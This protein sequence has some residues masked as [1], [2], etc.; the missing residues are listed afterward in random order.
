MIIWNF[1]WF[2]P[3]GFD[4]QMIFS[5]PPKF[6]QKLIWALISFLRFICFEHPVLHVSLTERHH[7]SL[8]PLVLTPLYFCSVQF[9]CIIYIITWK[10]FSCLSG[11]WRLAFLS[12]PLYISPVACLFLA[13]PDWLEHRATLAKKNIQNSHSL[14]L[15]L[16]KPLP[17][18]RVYWE[19]KSV[20][21]ICSMLCHRVFVTWLL[22]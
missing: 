1:D 7:L 13:L 22:Y 8:S 15:S 17:M 11:V 2:S 5:E 18:G 9:M 16:L 6:L 12:P 10:D 20:A 3:P 4:S 19:A 14:H 21:W